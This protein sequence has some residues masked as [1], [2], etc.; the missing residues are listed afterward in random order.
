MVGDIGNMGRHN[1][2][3]AP[4][5]MRRIDQLVVQIDRRIVTHHGYAVGFNTVARALILGKMLT[6][7]FRKMDK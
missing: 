5:L 2:E 3:I 4:G 1:D 6:D 7:R